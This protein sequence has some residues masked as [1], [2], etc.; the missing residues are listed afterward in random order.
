MALMARLHR[1]RPCTEDE[2]LRAASI[3]SIGALGQLA[4]VSHILAAVSKPNM[5][6]PCPKAN[7]V[8]AV[9]LYE[10]AAHGN[11]ARAARDTW[12]ALR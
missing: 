1:E 9:L 7:I 6:S 2:W 10:A 4:D 3:Q 5:S 8:A 11:V 12:E